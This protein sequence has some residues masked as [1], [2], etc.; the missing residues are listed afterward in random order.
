M[1][2]FLFLIIIILTEYS[3][4]EYRVFKLIIKDA[5]TGL[6]REVLSTLDPF[7]YVGYYPVKDSESID[8]TETWRCF[9][10]SSHFKD[11][12]PNPKSDNGLDSNNKV[13]P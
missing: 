7:Q 9:E 13:Q 10:D 4:A 1:R 8:Y 6:T 5:E 2:S 3:W 11:Y 12:C